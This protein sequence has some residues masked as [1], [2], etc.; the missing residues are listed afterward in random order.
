MGLVL[1][2]F[3]PQSSGDSELSIC[4]DEYES[5]FKTIIYCNQRWIDEQGNGIEANSSIEDV[6]MLLDL[7]M[8]EFKL[9]KDFKTQLYKACCFFLFLRTTPCVFK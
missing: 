2:N 1:Q 9:H 5:V 8:V 3:T 4:Q 6:S 7:P